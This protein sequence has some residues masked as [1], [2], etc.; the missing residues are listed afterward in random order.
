MGEGF[1]D[2]VGQFAI[3]VVQIVVDNQVSVFV[4]LVL[5]GSILEV[6]IIAA[7]VFAAFF[8]HGKEDGVV[9]HFGAKFIVPFL[10][11]QHAGFGAGM[12]FEGVAVQ[13]H[14][15]EDAGP[16]GDEFS[17]VFVG[18]VVEAAL[19]QHDGHASAGFEKV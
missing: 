9:I 12:R 17:N 2:A 10:H 5:S 19:R 6:N 16:L 3:V 4:Q 1:G 11:E 15:G 13:S 18:G 7:S 14:D 8:A